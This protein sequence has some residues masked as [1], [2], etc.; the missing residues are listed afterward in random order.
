MALLILILLFGLSGFSY[1]LAI[2]RKVKKDLP[3]K[4][5]SEVVSELEKI[6]PYFLICIL[7]FEDSNFYKH[8]GIDWVQLFKQIKNFIKGKKFGG[9]STIT[10]QLAKLKFGKFKK[11]IRRKLK[12]ILYAIVIERMFTKEEIFLLYLQGICWENL[13]PVF[14]IH[15]ASR[16]YF[17]KTPEK[18]NLME[19]V[20][21][22]FNV[23]SP[24]YYASDIYFDRLP[25]KKISQYYLQ[26][27]K[28]MHFI[29]SNF[30]SEN[31]NHDLIKKVF[32]KKPSA[33]KENY[34]CRS[35]E[36]KLVSRTFDEFC[37][38]DCFFENVRQNYRL[39]EESV[40]KIKA[41]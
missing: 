8:R 31:I 1:F 38:K 39:Y 22:S 24:N 34:V 33:H 13:I 26:L 20:L 25:E 3:Q 17:N 27:H 41:Q 19:S 12:S 14:G 40:E 21:L 9:A 29:E 35:T 4:K 5:M 6:S 28:I 37:D 10:Q 18:L 15:E 16:L 11:S 23:R 30:N 36:R 7:H 2:C 32:I